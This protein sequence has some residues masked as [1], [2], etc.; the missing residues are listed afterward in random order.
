MKIK[1]L[2]HQQKQL[3][4]QGKERG[5]FVF[6]QLISY[7]CLSLNLMYHVIAT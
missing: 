7:L 5:Y 3:H 6:F 1:H 4:A 2:N